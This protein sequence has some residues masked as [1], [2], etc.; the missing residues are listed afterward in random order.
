MSAKFKEP[1]DQVDTKTPMELTEE[2]LMSQVRHVANRVLLN[3]KSNDL[4][5]ANI[6]QVKLKTYVRTLNWMHSKGYIS[7]WSKAS[8]SECIQRLK[9]DQEAEV[10]KSPP[11]LSTFTF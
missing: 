4:N 11:A 3:L 1:S 7:K 6:E 5:S 9:N 8:V 2:Y 10:P